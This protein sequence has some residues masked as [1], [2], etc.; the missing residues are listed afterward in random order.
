MR[1][2]SRNRFAGKN[3]W[4]MILIL[5]L[6][7]FARGMYILSYLPIL[8][9]TAS[10]VTVGIVSFAITLHFISDALTNFGVGFMLK[11]YGTKIVLNSGFIL[12]IV[13]LSLVVFFQNPLSLIIAAILTGIAVSPIW[14]IMLSSIDD[15]KRSKHMGYVYFAWLVGMMTGMIMMNLIFKV[16][17]TKFTFLMPVFAFIAW[18]LYLFVHVEVSFFEKKSLKTQALH[19]KQVMMRHLL[20]F[21]G[22]LIQGLA[23]G[24]LVPIL[25]SYAINNLH[26]TTLEYTYILIAGGVGC[27]ISMLFIS[28][29]MDDVSNVYSYIVILT[30]FIVYGVAIFFMTQIS[31]YYLVLI[32][33]L[34]IGI[35]YGLLLPG[36]NAFMAS[37]VEPKL[38]EESWGV[39]NSLQGIGTMLGPVIGGI[40]TELFHNTNVTLFI[41][42][43]LFIFLALFYGIYFIRVYRQN[44]RAHH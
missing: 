11:R 38:K 26:V 1:D 2:S 27:T 41:S 39:F 28:K 5:F 19:I 44:K 15:A 3:F 23:I 6:M 43:S 30:G 20:L 10:K 17:P 12:A 24:M 33:A 18:C 9:T 34:V 7:E 36:W 14:V 13:G 8:P 35:F 22:I 40:L 32:S 29:F 16:H 42:A 31:N 4:L 25:P 37:Q 21:P